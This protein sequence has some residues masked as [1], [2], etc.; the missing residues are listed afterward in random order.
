[1]FITIR[2]SFGGKGADTSL[3][4]SETE[5]RLLSVNFANKIADVYAFAANSSARE[6]PYQ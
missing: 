2:A 1:M 4:F 3:N 6:L 5:I